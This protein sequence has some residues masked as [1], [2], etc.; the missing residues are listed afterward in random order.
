MR[1]SGG[2]RSIAWRSFWG[3]SPVLM[4]TLTS[5]PMPRSG[6]R[7]LR[8]MSYERAFSGETYT[9]RVRF[10]GTGSAT[11]RSSPQR[12]AAS[13]LPEPV[14]ADSRTFS[15]RAM[16]GHACVCASV[17][18]SK[19]RRNHSRTSGVKVESGSTATLRLRD[20][21]RAGSEPIGAPGHA[22]AV[23]VDLA[24]GAAGVTDRAQ[25]EGPLRDPPADRP[26][27]LHVVRRAVDL[28][29]VRAAVAEAARL[30]DRDA[31]DRGRDAAAR[32]VLARH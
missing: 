23:A 30:A 22:P 6:A 8:S 18:A 15:P 28:L 4:A 26:G 29:A 7:R 11:R 20:V 17:G 21:R 10:S 25:P 13:V 12:N 3:V 24:L 16:A 2:V 1:T 27:H 32:A 14:G 31:E 5:P 19:A 9:S